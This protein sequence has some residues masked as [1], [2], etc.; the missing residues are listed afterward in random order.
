MSFCTKE[1]YSE[2][3]ACSRKQRYIGTKEN[4]GRRHL[5]LY[6]RPGKNTEDISEYL[7]LLSNAP[8]PKFQH[9]DAGF[10]IPVSVNATT[11]Y[12]GTDIFLK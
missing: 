7:E 3:Q 2:F 12:F 9:Q 4:P 10:P 8:S 5:T 6:S 11:S 1:E